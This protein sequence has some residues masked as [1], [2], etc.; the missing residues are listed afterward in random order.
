MNMEYKVVVSHSGEDLTNKVK[1]YIQ[2]GWKPVG[3]HSVVEIHRQNRYSGQQHMDTRIEVEYS[4]SIVRE[5]KLDTI[6]VDVSYYYEDDTH[7]KVK[8]YDEEGMREDFEYK[9]SNLIKNS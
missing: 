3:G 4:I 5:V 9:L 7:Q 6:E 8:V 2:D 1:G